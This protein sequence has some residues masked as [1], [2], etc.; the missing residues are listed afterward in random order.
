MKRQ[1]HPSGP[2]TLDAF[3]AFSAGQMVVRPHSVAVPYVYVGL[4]HS[5]VR[6]SIP[7]YVRHEY[8][9]EKIKPLFAKAGVF[10]A[11]VVGY[12]KLKDE[13]KASFKE[14]LQTFK[15]DE[16]FPEDEVDQVLPGY[17]L[18]IDGDDDYSRIE[19]LGTSRYLDGDIWVAVSSQ[20][21]D[22]VV[23]RFL[24]LADASDL[25]TEREELRQ[26]VER[27]YDGKTGIISQYDQA[28]R[29]FESQLL[30]A[31]IWDV[32]L[33]HN[34]ADKPSVRALAE[35]LRNRGL[36]VWFDEWELVPGKPWQEAIEEVL[37]TIRAAAVFVG[38]EG[39]GP[40]HNRE[41]R[42]CLSELVERGLPVIPVLL[43][44]RQRTPDLPIFLKQVTWVDFRDGIT[45]EGMTRLLWGITGQKS[46]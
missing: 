26:D 12:L 37:G 39:I 23:S 17:V 27:L 14:F 31:R 19:Y 42:A 28:D 2:T 41:M 25:A 6:N 11:R 29:L 9:T 45:E 34:S 33:S 15:L 10:E 38:Q 44:G 7:V 20:D 5:I 21:V 40:W 1:G 46:T 36:R 24:D 4:Y 16:I 43:P 22:R 30:T 18:Q 13:V 35:E 8:F 3:L 32:F